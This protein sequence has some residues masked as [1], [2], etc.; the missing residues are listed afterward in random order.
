[1]VLD[2]S[3]AL[4]VDRI[5]HVLDLGDNYEAGVDCVASGR[6]RSKTSIRLESVVERAA[7]DD[8]TYS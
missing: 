7:F 2:N 4:E 3:P 6:C 8:L 1:M 5:K